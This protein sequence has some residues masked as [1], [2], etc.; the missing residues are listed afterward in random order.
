M[1][2]NHGLNYREDYLAEYGDPE[3]NNAKVRKCTLIIRNK[4]NI[5]IL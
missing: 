4:S 2:T 3:A 5:V 1:I